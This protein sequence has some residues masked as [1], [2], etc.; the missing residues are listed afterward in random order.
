MSSI[1]LPSISAQGSLDKYLQRVQAVSFLVF[2]NDLL[3]WV[4]SVERLRKKLLDTK[5]KRSGFG[6][7]AKKGGEEQ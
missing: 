7:L 5:K 1:T 4:T 2:S 3:S 6:N